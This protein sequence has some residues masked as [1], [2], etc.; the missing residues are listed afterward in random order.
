MLLFSSMGYIGS[1]KTEE[2]PMAD[3]YYV[4]TQARRVTRCIHKGPGAGPVSPAYLQGLDTQAFWQAYNTLRDLLL[5]YYAQAERDPA[6][7]ALPSHAIDECKNTSPEAREGAAALANLPAALIALG[8]AGRVEGNVLSVNQAALKATLKTVHGK[9]LPRQIAWLSD[10]GFQFPS[11]MGKAFPRSEERIAVEYPDNADVLVVLVAWGDKLAKHLETGVKA[12]AMPLL[13]E[14]IALEPA[15]FAEDDGI[16]PAMTIDRFE[17]VIDAKDRAAARAIVDRMAERGLTL[18]FD[19]LYLK[20]RF[21]NEKGKDTLNHLEF[22]DYRNGRDGNET[23]SLRLKLNHPDAYIEQVE[24]LPQ[25]LKKQFAEP[26]CGNCMDNCNRRITY[27]LEGQPKR[28]C[29]CFFFAFRSPAVE[30]LDPLLG[31]Y[32]A[33]QVARKAK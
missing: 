9:H 28:A 32:D 24:A 27:T 2:K 4:Q 15:L 33:E 25:H 30:D 7:L 8:M 16:L 21:F 18:R 10:N 13:S 17:R 20:N 12:T 23:L 22:G 6:S 31:L 5:H 14:F 1:K 19:S 26:W 11:W 3:Q 29:G